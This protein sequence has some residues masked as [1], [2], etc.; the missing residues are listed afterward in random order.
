MAFSVKVKLNLPKAQQ[1]VKAAGLEKDGDVQAFHTLNVLRRIQ[2]YMPYR[3]GATIKQTIN[4]TTHT[5]I[6]T[7]TPYAAMLYF[8]KVMVDSETGVAGF[9][10]DDGWKSRKGSTKVPTDRDITYTKEKNPL[11]GPY[12]DKALVAN[13]GNLLVQELQDYIDKR[14]R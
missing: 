2:R 11:A 10:T 1:I 3:T 9:L 14:K 6:V 5:E 12:W 8:G 7:N 4:A 13:E